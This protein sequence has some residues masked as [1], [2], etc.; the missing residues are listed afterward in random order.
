MSKSWNELTE[1]EKM[2]WAAVYAQIFIREQTHPH[3]ELVSRVARNFANQ[4]IQEL[5]S[6]DPLPASDM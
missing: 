5:S 2:I 3:R 1:R 6:S 4:A